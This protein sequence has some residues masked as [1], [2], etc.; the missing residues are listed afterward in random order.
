MFQQNYIYKNSHWVGF[1][2]WVIK[3]AGNKVS[4]GF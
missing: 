3:R 1:G 4:M 2:P